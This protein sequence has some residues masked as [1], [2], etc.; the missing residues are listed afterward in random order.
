MTLGLCPKRGCQAHYDKIAMRIEE[1]ESQLNSML[2]QYK[3]SCPSVDMKY[4]HNRKGSYLIE[5]PGK[6]TKLPKELEQI[7]ALKVNL[8][9]H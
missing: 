6:P 9:L 1:I 4:I 8:P 3:Q 5:I 2:E 7:E